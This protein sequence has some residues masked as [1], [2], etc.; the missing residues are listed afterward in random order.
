ML[1]LYVY[2]YTIKYII[3]SGVTI[4]DM[5]L[6]NGVRCTAYTESLKKV[7]LVDSSDSTLKI[8][9]FFPMFIIRIILIN[10]ILLY[11]LYYK[12]Y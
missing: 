1:N 12:Y 5:T 7:R 4:T 6:V 10:S 2:Y 3:D 11:N 9:N 8:Y